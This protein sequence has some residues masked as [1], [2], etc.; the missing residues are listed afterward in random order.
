MIKMFDIFVLPFSIGLL[1][2]AGILLHKYAGWVKELDTAEKEKIKKGIFSIRLFSGIKEVFMECLLHRRIFRVNPL[3]WYMHAAIAFG[4]FLLIFIGFIKYGLV[5]GNPIHLPYEVVFMEFFPHDTSSIPYAAGFTF[6]MDFFLLIV[7][8]GITLALVKR[9]ASRMF[10]M[11]KTTRLKLGDKVALVSLWLIFPVR[12]IA[13]SF[14]AGVHDTGGF[15]TATLGGF[16]AGVLPVAEL[17]YPVW[18]MYSIVLGAFF[19]SVPFSRYMHIPTEVL[20][21]FSRNFGIKTENKFSSFSEMEVN[22]CPRCGICIDK[23]QLNTS[24]NITDT[25]SVYFVR[26]IREGCVEED[27]A[28]NCLLCGR[29]KEFCPVQIDTTTLR[30]IKRKEFVD[31]D[32]K[33]FDYLEVEENGKADVIYFAGCMTHLTPKTK[34]SMLKILNKANVNYLFLDSDGGA[35]CGRP[36]MMVGRDKKARYLIEHNEKLIKNSG[37]KVFVTSCPVCYKVFKEDYNLDCVRVMHHTEYLLKLIKTGKLRVGWIDKKVTYHDPCKLARDFGIHDEPRELLEECGAEL[38][39]AKDEKES[40]LCCGNSLGNLKIRN[41]EKDAITRDVLNELTLNNPDMIVTA[42]PLC[43]ETFANK[44][45]I[46]VED[47]SEV[48]AESIN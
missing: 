3:L 14:T 46:E 36:L 11:E 13:E 5:T 26:S 44:S 41:D 16:F 33:P 9:T 31:F 34:E 29:C 7:L 20:L 15:L 1:A 8:S 19:V 6:L 42:C 23:C 38:A 25:Q 40:A 21:I 28:F 48:V 43:K 47:I 2:L 39:P 37:A 12:L 18:W 17:T 4:W 22:S 24:A 32:D 45:D 35:C 10:G 27:K 30:T